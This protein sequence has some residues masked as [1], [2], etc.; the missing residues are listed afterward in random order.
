MIG[1]PASASGVRRRVDWRRAA[2]LLAEGKTHGEVAHA[3][4]CAP[5]TIRRRLARDRQ[6]MDTV[7]RMAARHDP[8]EERLRTLRQTCQQAIED[9]VQNGNVRVILWLADRLKLI[10]PPD[11]R[12]PQNELD[13]L[14][15]TMSASELEEFEALTDVI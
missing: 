11:Q 14:I 6:L 7:A 8:E 12:T 15:G 9:E 2:Q 3:L 5:S 4:G 1:A 13:D 10:R